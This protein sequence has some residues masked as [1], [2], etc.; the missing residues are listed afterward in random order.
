MLRTDP[1]PDEISGGHMGRLR[2]L[3]E[4]SDRLTAT[5][6]LHRE[7]LAGGIES[8]DSTALFLLAAAS[9]MRAADYARLHSMLPAL[10]VAS[11]FGAGIP[12]GSMQR[13][14]SA[15]TH[16]VWLPRGLPLVCIDCIREDMDHWG[17]SW[18]R[19]SHQLVGVDW[20]DKHGCELARVKSRA[21]FWLTPHGQAMSGAL[22][23]VGAYRRTFGTT[24]TFVRRYAAIAF[25]ML[26]MAAPAS[27]ADINGR[28]AERAD[29]LGINGRDSDSPRSLA[30]SILD[31]A[32]E[33]WLS[34]HFP[35]ITA[36]GERSSI[37]SVD[38]VLS[39][40]NYAPEGPIYALAMAALYEDADLAVQAVFG[41]AIAAACHGMSDA[42]CPRLRP[43]PIE[44]RRSKA[45]GRVRR[46]E[47]PGDIEQPVAQSTSQGVS[48]RC[49]LTNDGANPWRG[50]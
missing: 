2:W 36:S 7:L 19:R 12:H 11:D 29:L 49:R 41:S 13:T 42:G 32:P 48:L 33:A 43:I 16:G 23:W 37:A 10:R 9:N 31:Q 21:P 26:V 25:A 27:A 17:F 44:S 24:S 6:A 30:R 3:N 18:Y 4:W 47:P 35:D 28:L 46:N 39:R 15:R 8:E 38:K 34:E 22:S 50:R 14:C 1:M 40:M 45:A 5:Q 20:C